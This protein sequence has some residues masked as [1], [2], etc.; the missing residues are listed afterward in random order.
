[1]NSGKKG[2]VVTEADYKR[3]VKSG[4]NPMSTDAR[5][6]GLI[7]DADTSC[8]YSYRNFV[9]SADGYVVG[10]MEVAGYANSETGEKIQV[11]ILMNLQGKFTRVSV[12]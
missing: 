12:K 4:F 3:L 9:Y 10:V 1:M 8:I 5:D 11:T 2:K 7:V 6:L